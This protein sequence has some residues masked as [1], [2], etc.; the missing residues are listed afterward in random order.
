MLWLALALGQEVVEL[1]ASLWLPSVDGHLRFDEGENR[2]NSIDEWGWHRGWSPAF[3]V[4]ADFGADAASIR[5]SA[6][7]VRG[8]KV[9]DVPLR[10]NES[11]FVAGEEV[12]SELMLLQLALGYDRTLLATPEVEIRAGLSARYVRTKVKTSAPTPGRDD[13]TLGAFIPELVVGGRAALGGGWAVVGEVAGSSFSA[14]DLTARTFT[15]AGHVEWTPSEAW[16]VRLGWR[17]ESLDLVSRDRV[18]RNEADLLLQGPALELRCG[19]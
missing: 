19:F 3:G 12:E 11:Q 5:A 17:L 14:F 10:W 16:S 13:D 2:G 1:E 6:T 7:R 8:Q 15:I 18:Q 9:F 4:R